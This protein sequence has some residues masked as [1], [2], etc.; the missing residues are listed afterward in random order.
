MQSATL[1]SLPTCPGSLQNGWRLGM[2]AMLPDEQEIQANFMVLSELEKGT[3]AN[4]NGKPKKDQKATTRASAGKSSKNLLSKE[5]KSSTK[6]TRQTSY[7][8]QTIS[9]RTQK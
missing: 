8:A 5:T 1:V 6:A 2:T 3:N 9:K 4:K 7:S